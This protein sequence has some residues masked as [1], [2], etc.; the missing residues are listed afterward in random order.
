MI[1][2]I[3]IIRD[4]VIL[5]YQIQN[6]VV[7]DHRYQT[8]VFIIIKKILY[9]ICRQHFRFS[10]IQS[11][12]RF[13]VDSID[14][15]KKS[16]IW[17]S[18]WIF[19]KSIFKKIV[20]RFETSI[21]TFYSIIFFSTNIFTSITIFE[22]NN[23]FD[24]SLFIDVISFDNFFIDNSQQTKNT[25]MTKKIQ[26]NNM[27]NNVDNV[28]NVDVNLNNNNYQK[29]EFCYDKSSHKTEVKISWSER[30]SVLTV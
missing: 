10:S 2:I 1:S 17:F 8:F 21:Q 15:Q 20:K 5:V 3:N 23:I 11:F 30:I 7:I 19:D 9:E 6:F 4:I 25:S 22:S 18:D 12:E 24:D 27:S 26:R 13:R 29:F 28:D 16:R 14:T